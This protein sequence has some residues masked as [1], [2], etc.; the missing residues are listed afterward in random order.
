MSR[1]AAAMI[2]Y[3]VLA[4]LTVMTIT[5]TRLRAG[6][7]AILALFAFKSWVRRKDVLHTDEENEAEKGKAEAEQ[8]S[9]PM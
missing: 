8:I 2:A 3:A 4:G 1:L 6:T 7:L 9:E 5:D